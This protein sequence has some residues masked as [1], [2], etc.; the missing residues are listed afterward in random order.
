MRTATPDRP[1]PC[2]GSSLAEHVACPCNPS[3]PLLV[4]VR[5]RDDAR[6][7]THS[8]SPRIANTPFEQ[9]YCK[10]MLHAAKHTS[11]SVIGL[12]IGSTVSSHCPFSLCLIPSE[13]SMKRI[14]F[15]KQSTPLSQ[16]L[17]DH[18]FFCLSAV[19]CISVSACRRE[20]VF[21]EHTR[22]PRDLT[23]P[24]TTSHPPHPPSTRVPNAYIRPR[25]RTRASSSSMWCRSSISRR[26]RPCSRPLPC[27][28]T[29]G[30][31]TTGSDR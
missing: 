14:V 10:I 29:S 22:A 12:C 13:S 20:R 21:D 28:S 31:P 7:A 6:V 27:S 18:A 4:F 26:S 16:T 23:S 8:P 25:E 5:E 19:F 24:R 11:A 2:R 9:Q 15:N 30:R 17:S 1:R 3:H